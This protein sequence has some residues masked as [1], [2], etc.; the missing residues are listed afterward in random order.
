MSSV[1]RLAIGLGVLLSFCTAASAQAT[2]E[3]RVQVT[4]VDPSN[5]VVPG[6]TVTLQP[7]ESPGQPSTMPVTADDK[8]IAVID[9][10][11]PGR[12]SVHAEFPGFDPGLLP[13][14]RI[15]AGDNKQVVILPLAK[16]EQTVT[17]GRDSQEAA[18]DRHGSEFGT[19]LAPEQVDALSD[20]PTELAQQLA[21]LGGPDAVI[22]VDS[23]EGQ[24]LPPKAQ[25]KSVHVVRDQFAAEA[26]QPGT[27]FIDV[28]TQPGVGPIRGLMNVSFRNTGMTAK[29]PFVSTRGPEQAEN[30]NGNLG[31]SLLKGKTSFSASIRGQTQ[32]TTPLIN[33]A[34]PT[35][36]FLSQVSNLRTQNDQ[37]NASVVVDQALTRDQTLRVSYNADRIRI[38]N[39]G[40]GSFNLAD[41]AYTGHQYVHTVRVQEAGP[42][43]RRAFL[44]TRLAVGRYELQFDSATQ[45]PAIVV[46]D[47]FISGGAQQTGGPI[48][49]Q[50]TLI[51]DLDYV[52]GI[53]SWRAGVQIDVY[54]M[55]SDLNNNYLGTYTFSSLDAYNAGQP[56]LYTRTIGNPHI[57]YGTFQL[58]SYVQDDVRL[59]KGLTLSPGVRYSLEPAVSDR[60]AFEPRF[61]ITWA[62]WADGKTTFRASAGIFHGFRQRYIIE[63]ST[64]FDGAHQQEI[65]VL[66]PSYPDPGS[67]GLV[68]PSDR[69]LVGDNF[70][71]QQN[72]RY[73]A[74]V[75]RVISPRVKVNVLYNYIHLQQQARGENLN[76]PLDGVRPDPLFANVIAAVTDAE[77]R[78]HEIYVNSTISLAA[79]SPT[80]NRD[81]FNWRRIQATAGYTMIH[82]RNNSDGPFSPPPSGTPATE[83]GPG[84]Q[85]APYRFNVILTAT[86]FRNF[87]Q[88]ITWIANSGYPYTLTTGFDDNHDGIVNDRPPGVG[89]HSLRTPGQSTINAR[90][91]YAWI[92][93]D[94]PNV[95]NAQPRYRINL[96]ASVNNLT[97]HANPI[98]FSGVLTSPFFEQATAVMNP[99]KVDVG[100]NVSF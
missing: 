85:D 96:F 71:L 77:I 1:R 79:P 19:E 30:Y 70:H 13:D 34:L 92:L 62:P 82:A 99:R 7:I 15:R 65:L 20:D 38:S 88:A 48:G 23:F 37:M 18:A 21:D 41:R 32:Y 64:H 97:N 29:S 53:N 74:G 76:A 52:R 28:V 75:D 78:R 12:Y 45:A 50:T 11:A 33:V 83:W 56:L 27:T 10:V 67:A 100:M 22:R 4:V 36:G 24:Q 59:R 51:S 2:R 87:T 60:L 93:R 49:I 89:L 17:V 81:R 61:G 3:G 95:P 44:N 58:G 31:G 26:A 8:G 46:Q 94:T 63:Q 43:G 54:R 86:Q 9:H 57:H 91:T 14:V 47:A 66:N 39:L 42:L 5:A 68:A 80:L 6:A 40:V 84:G 25:I 55:H 98:G 69:Y 16:L 90:F 73:S 72:L 35:G